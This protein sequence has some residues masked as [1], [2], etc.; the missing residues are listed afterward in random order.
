LSISTTLLAPGQTGQQYSSTLAATGGTPSYTWSITSGTLPAGLS[1]MA[2][3]GQITGTPTAT[4]QSS[5][6]VQVKDSAATPATATQALTITAVIAGALDQYGGR[7]DINCPA[8]SGWTTAKI[9]NRW[10]ICTPAGHGLFMEG[11]MAVA[12]YGSGTK[13]SSS[14]QYYQETAA[15]IQG[16]NFNT[17]NWYVA[18][19]VWPSNM[20]T[21]QKMPVWENVK[22][23]YYSMRNP[24]VETTNNGNIRL[25]P[26]PVKDLIYIHSPVYTDWIYNGVPDTYDPKLYTWL[27]Q[28]LAQ[29]ALWPR[30]RLQGSYLMGLGADDSDQMA[31]YKDGGDFATVPSGHNSFHLSWM[32]AT[33]SPVQTAKIDNYGAGAAAVYADTTVYLKKA[34]H[35]Y[36][37]GKYGTVAA[38]NAAWGSNY[39]TFDS[40]G[41]TVTG[42]SMGTGD[43]STKTFSHTLAQTP[44]SQFTIQV[45]VNGTVVAGDARGSTFY[46]PTIAAGGTINYATGAI[47]ITFNSAPA[48]G[49]TITVNY[50][51]NGWTYGTGVLD[52]DG[53]SSHTWIGQDWNFLKTTNA[54]VRVDFDAFLKQ[55]SDH[56]FSQHKTAFNTYFPGTLF[57]SDFGGWAAPAWGAALQGASPYVD[58]FDYSTTGP[59]MTQ[60]MLTYYNTN[61]GDKPIYFAS[62]LTANADSPFSG[63]N[64]S[65]DDGKASQAARGQAYLNMI[66]QE[67]NT[68]NSQGIYPMVG[69]AWWS[70]YDDP[71]QGR[72]WGLKTG[73]DNAYDG[74]EAVTAT[75]SCSVPLQAFSCGGQAANYGDAIT[76]IHDANALWLTIP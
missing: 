10:W 5:F 47:T 50:Q 17:W 11:L 26:E 52:E 32:V 30:V 34:W 60:A 25:L 56:Y 7:T 66:N 6:T 21:A 29:E 58:V 64:D 73:G 69:I 68:A 44:V 15:E 48:S 27:N 24:I 46:G 2:S 63:T 9:N 51:Q 70:L 1:L 59:Y 20:P 39:T 12:P 74:R 35:D 61:A 53:R 67:L 57:F 55:V 62:F 49:A 4:G 18:A 8:A 38:L 75:V 37:V 65:G 22:A 72:N 36:L 42:E 19:G 54:T 40:S 41:T 28:D 45:L 76:Q 71:G 14:T 16:W 31:G 43:G 3:S 13:Y 33:C 23:G